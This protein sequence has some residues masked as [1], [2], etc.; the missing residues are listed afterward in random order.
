METFIAKEKIPDLVRHLSKN[1]KVI[2]PTA[3]GP[4]HVFLE[5]NDPDAVVLDYSTTVLPPK[6]FFMPTKEELLRFE[7]S[8]GVVSATPVET[9]PKVFLGLH[10]YDMHGILRLDFLMKEGNPDKTY[11]ARRENSYFIGT[12]FVPDE[13]HFSESVGIPIDDTEGFDAFMTPVDGGYVLK[14]LTKEGENLMKGYTEDKKPAESVPLQKFQKKVMLDLVRIPSVLDKAYSSGVWMEA[15]DKCFSCGSCNLVCPTCYCFDVD[16]EVALNLNEGT[17]LR[18]WDAC[19]LT[20][21][22]EVAGGESFRKK[23]EARVRHRVYR[24]FRYLMNKYP[25]PLCVGCG[26][27]IR[28]CT[29]KIDIVEMLNAAAAV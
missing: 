2:A 10:S 1:H 16:D 28:A 26:R 29:A 6:K 21:F 9:V 15:G 5:I 4:T 11:L 13:E 12:T 20:S 19:Q 23:R 14:T 3:K 7:R 27:C 22:A 25:K 17:R 8:G 24:K 18:M